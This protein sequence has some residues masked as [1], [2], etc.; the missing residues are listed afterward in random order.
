MPLNITIE[1]G[2]PRTIAPAE[3]S[4][5]NAAP[6]V[7]NDGKTLEWSHGSASNDLTPEE[8]RAIKPHSVRAARLVKALMHT[9]PLPAIVRHFKG[10]RG[11]G[12]RTVRGV[13][14]ALRRA[15]GGPK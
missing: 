3:T 7:I 6:V 14:A 9:K 5:L 12:E 11:M 4:L 1:H 8:I 10:V 15:G 2:K 13:Y